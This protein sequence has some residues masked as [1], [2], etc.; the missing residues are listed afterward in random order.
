MKQ[1][2]RGFSI[3][4]LAVLVFWFGSRYSQVPQPAYA[5]IFRE[6]SKPLL[7]QYRHAPADNASLGWRVSRINTNVIPYQVAQHEGTIPVLFDALGH[8]SPTDQLLTPD[9]LVPTKEKSDT[10]PTASSPL[11]LVPA[12]RFEW[13][14]WGVLGLIPVNAG[15]N[16]PRTAV[17]K[18][19][20]SPQEMASGQPLAP[21]GLL[22]TVAFFTQ[23]TST[24][25]ALTF[26]LDDAVDFRTLL[27]TAGRDAPGRDAADVPRYPGL[28][29]SYTVEETGES[30]ESLVIVYTGQGS[31]PTIAN[32]YRE[33]MAGLGWGSRDPHEHATN[34]YRR[35]A[36][37]VFLQKG[38]ECV[39]AIESG[40]APG[41]VQTV[42]A[43]R[44]VREK[45]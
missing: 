29:R 35:D 28:Q 1:L 19:G 45:G 24:T 26:W 38:K 20:A 13:E 5:E 12:F 22:A 18:L 40:S 37:F 4:I 41:A 6:L 11:Q 10:S 23:N 32:F 43:V 3:C 33:R 17:P 16:P 34:A 39:I 36:T 15:P 30:F 25:T 44:A 14:N 42:V 31:V 8:T 21:G 2:F 27:P 7:F 9:A